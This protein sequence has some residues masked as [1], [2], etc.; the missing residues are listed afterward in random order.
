MWSDE[1][2]AQA[3]D[4]HK[5][6][7]AQAKVL[8]DLRDEAQ[9][10]IEYFTTP[11]V[12]GETFA[13]LFTDEGICVR[14]GEDAGGAT[15]KFSEWL[16]IQENRE[17]AEKLLAED[18]AKIAELE[19]ENNALLALVTQKSERI[20]E[21]ANALAV[22]GAAVKESADYFAALEAH[23]WLTIHETNL[24]ATMRAA[25]EKSETFGE[26]CSL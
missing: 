24:L 4:E 3:I 20:E 6:S 21:L 16:K 19:A 10:R 23:P 1:E 18:A 9:K 13:H 25:L 26:R 14:C 22:L 17:N 2:L 7:F 15:M 11:R 8:M 12:E 5:M